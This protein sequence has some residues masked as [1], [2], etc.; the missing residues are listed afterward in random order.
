M[1]SAY[2]ASGTITESEAL[3]LYHLAFPQ[4]Y[5]AIINRLGYPYQRSEAFDVYRLENRPQRI[6]IRYQG[7]TAIGWQVAR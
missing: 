6:I 4:S 7:T 5:R 1:I 3:T 2:G